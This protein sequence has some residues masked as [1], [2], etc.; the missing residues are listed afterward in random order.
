MNGR[1]ICGGTETHAQGSAINKSP[2][3]HPAPKSL[4]APYKDLGCMNPSNEYREA[5]FVHSFLPKSFPL[6]LLKAEGRKTLSRGWNRQQTASLV[7]GVFF[8]DL[9]NSLHVE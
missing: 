9:K 4:E 8:Y 2:S 6:E 5:M 7:L 3:P 1:C